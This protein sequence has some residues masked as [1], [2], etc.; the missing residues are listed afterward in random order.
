MSALHRSIKSWLT[1]LDDAT[2]L[3][4]GTTA[5]CFILSALLGLASCFW[6]LGSRSIA[7][8]FV[9]SFYLSH[10]VFGLLKQ[11]WRHADWPATLK[12]DRIDSQAVATQHASQWEERAAA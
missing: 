8:F 5:A 4:V 2:R 6:P 9:G 3:C 10:A 11:H 1:A 7:L 12:Q